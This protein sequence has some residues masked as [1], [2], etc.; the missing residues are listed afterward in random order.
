MSPNQAEPTL[1][2]LG[3]I[4]KIM[5]FF[6]PFLVIFLVI[7]S[8]TAETRT[9]TSRQGT[10]IEATLVEFTED[11]VKLKKPDGTVMTVKPSQLSQA[12]RDFL[13]K[14]KENAVRPA[15]SEDNSS[16]T[17]IEVFAVSVSKEIPQSEN[18]DGQP[19]MTRMRMGS[20]PGT[21]VSFLIPSPK[22]AEAL[23]LADEAKI[24]KFVDENKTDLLVKAKPKALFSGM[25]TMF[26]GAVNDSPLSENQIDDD[27]RWMIVDCFAPNRPAPGSKTVRVEGM[28][29][30][31]YGKGSKTSEHKNI[32]LDGKGKFSVAGET[33]TVVKSKNK[34]FNF[35]GSNRPEMKQTI[36]LSSKKPLDSFFS[37]TFY[38][39]KGKE[40]EF[41]QSMNGSMNDTFFENYDLAVEVDSLSI[42]VEEYETIETVKI[43]VSQTVGLGF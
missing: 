39:S 7:S 22:G 43:P 13:S 5:K 2:S 16:D 28:L 15:A 24:E 6:I 21:T 18:K 4:M 31:R 27:G 1:T 3:G 9:W 36:T 33:I 8:V 41:N 26:G 23:G 11:A 10:P 37:I 30:L 42:E 14:Q 38:D 34:P 12:D 17:K 40:I 35:P 25:T 29:V 32:P 19:P 20:Q